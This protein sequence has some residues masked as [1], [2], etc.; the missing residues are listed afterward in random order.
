VPGEFELEIPSLLSPKYTPGGPEPVVNTTNSLSWSGSVFTETYLVRITRS[1]GTLNLYASS[2]SLS[3]KTIWQNLAFSTSYSWKV[4]AC[5]AKNE[6]SCQKTADGATA[7]SETWR[8][9][10]TG[11]PPSGLRALPSQGESVG[12][13]TTL[14]WNEA[15]GA[16][17]Y[18]YEVSRDASFANLAAQGKESISQ[19]Q[20]AQGLEQNTQYWWRVRTC[21][22]QE[23]AVCGAWSQSSL[24]TATLSAPQ[25]TPNQS[26][27]T[28]SDT[29]FWQ[30]VFGSNVYAYEL[31]YTALGPEEVS[32]SCASSVGQI[33]SSGSVN[34]NSALLRLQ[35]TGN[36]SIRI[37]GC[38]DAECQD[39][40]PWSS[41]Q[42]FAVEQPATSGGFGLIPCGV[43][44][45]N[46]NTG[47]DERQSCGFGHALLLVRNLVDFALWKLSLIII[48]L[49]GIATGA[50]VY[51]SFGG[52]E[53]LQQIKSIWKAVGVGALILLFAWFFLNILLGLLEFDVSIFG[54]WSE[55][56]LR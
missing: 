33:T 50:M 3:F 46:P 13:P 26:L 29:L 24:R 28:P 19:A 45:D 37:R 2:P 48:V 1:S 47:W 51:F 10:T 21:A 43:G 15:P 36:Y 7:F 4:A 16:A 30:E 23:G 55:I 18:I 35:C 27:L 39:A 34:S 40:G 38:T 8:F 9:T 42:S 17:S 52:P 53:L 5:T 56:P 25:I 31:T 41:P 32:S 6:S 22:D 54:Q 44:V 12:I 11:A 14:D 49:L 20:V